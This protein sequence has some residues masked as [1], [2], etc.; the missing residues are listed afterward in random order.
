M[1]AAISMESSSMDSSSMVSSSMVSS[2]TR[3]LARCTHMG[4]VKKLPL[5]AVACRCNR[6]LC[7]MHR[8]PEDHGCTFDY[9]AAGRTMLSANNPVITCS[10][11]ERV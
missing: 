8:Y 5:T 9:R 3:H 11:L 1:S 4:C 7:G 2:S 6:L 10:K